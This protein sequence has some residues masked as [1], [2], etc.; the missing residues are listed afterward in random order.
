[1]KLRLLVVA[2]GRSAERDISCI[3]AA[4]ILRNLD[5]KRFD[6]LLVHIDAEGRWRLIRTPLAFANFPKP[7]KYPFSGP[8]CEIRL[9]GKRWLWSQGR[10]I[11]VD[12]VFPVLHGPMGEDGT[13]QGLFELAG[14]A[15]VGSDVA[16]SAVGM[17]KAVTKELALRAGL[18]V[19]P[20]TVLRKGDSLSSTKKLKLPV[21]VKPARLGSSVGVV[22][23]KK[24]P[25]LDKAVRE[26]F[27]YDTLVVV[28]QGVSPRE[29]E[30]AVLGPTHAPKASKIG[31]IRPNREFYDYTAKYL[32]PDGAA[33][34]V[35]AELSASQAKEIQKLSLKAFT[36]LG[37]YG[38]ARVDFLLDKKTGKLWFNEVNT[39]P[40]CTANSL[41]PR[42]W[43][44]SGVSFPK[45]INK[46][47]DLA[48]ARRDAKARLKSAP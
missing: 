29:V 21:F 39:L 24:W 34:L 30:C 14:A 4:A 1:M 16:G 19:L 10:A 35:P 44:A 33:I 23:V 3:S 45:L 27:K 46:L 15:Y 42:L 17:D 9:G 20:Y 38:L 26:A 6:P 18:P 25:E 43:G 7:W 36:A 2:G 41:Y 11:Q 5:R 40:G 12:A 47:V 37:C 32:D 28:E 31:E 13:I 22:K 8:E 48:L